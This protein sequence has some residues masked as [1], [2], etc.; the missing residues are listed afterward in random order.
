[1]TQQ[2]LG[3]DVPINIVTV[4]PATTDAIDLDRFHLAMVSREAAQP[5]A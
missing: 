4:R 2:R 3:R 5:A 1:V